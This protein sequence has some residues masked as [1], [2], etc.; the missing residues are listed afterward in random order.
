MDLKNN[1]SHSKIFLHYS[2]NEEAAYQLNITDKKV[3]KKIKKK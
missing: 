3:Q 1:N 2:Y